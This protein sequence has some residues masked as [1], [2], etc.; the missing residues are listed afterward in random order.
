M[1]ISGTWH[2]TAPNL[3]GI[4]VITVD[5]SNPPLEPPMMPNCL[6]VVSPRFSRSIATAAKSS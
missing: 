6:G 5:T 2:T 1:S 4:W 3:S